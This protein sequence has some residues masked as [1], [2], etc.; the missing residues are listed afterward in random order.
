MKHNYSSIYERRK[1]QIGM[2]VARNL[3]G[4]KRSLYGINEP[5]ANRLKLYQ[6]AP[7]VG[8]REKC[9]SDD[10]EA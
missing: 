10:Y 9:A 7:N 1:A 2:Q 8:F 6:D 3:S 5:F 4:K